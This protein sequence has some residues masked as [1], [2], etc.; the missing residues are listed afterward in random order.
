MISPIQYIGPATLMASQKDQ[1]LKRDICDRI[2]RCKPE[3]SY[4]VLAI[5]RTMLFICKGM[6]QKES[7]DI[8]NG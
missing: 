4:W 5:E 7:K 3:L 1:E 6:R 2:T 8:G